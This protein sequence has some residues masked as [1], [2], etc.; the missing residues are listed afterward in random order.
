M[1]NN[2]KFTE[3]EIETLKTME[4]IKKLDEKFDFDKMSEEDQIKYTPQILKITNHRINLVDSLD[5]DAMESINKKMNNI[6]K[7][8]RNIFN[9]ILNTIK[10]IIKYLKNNINNKS[11]IIA[12]LA[13][14]V[15]QI[16]YIPKKK[17][18]M[19]FSSQK[20]PHYIDGRKFHTFIFDK[21]LANSESN[22]AYYKIDYETLIWQLLITT[23]IFTIIYLCI[24]LYKKNQS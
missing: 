23:I 17:V 20:V 15:I 24:S 12:Y 19:V 5:V 13:A 7:N 4:K 14:L 11:I 8:K 21:Y 18:I 6:N 2:I 1:N 3:K 10:N 16:I 22:L 9:N